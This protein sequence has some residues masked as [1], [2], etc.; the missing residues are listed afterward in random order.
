[1][2]LRMVI[3]QFQQDKFLGT[4]VNLSQVSIVVTREAVD[5]TAI[6]VSCILLPNT[7]IFGKESNSQPGSLRR[8]ADKISSPITWTPL[9]QIFDLYLHAQIMLGGST[10]AVAPLLSSKQSAVSGILLLG[11]L[12]EQSTQH[13]KQNQ[14]RER[15]RQLEW[16]LYSQNGDLQQ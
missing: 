16:N 5:N 8:S 2:Q 11:A 14:R 15:T 7:W 1:M 9:R 4:G 13:N 10:Q 12:S 6:E 3:P